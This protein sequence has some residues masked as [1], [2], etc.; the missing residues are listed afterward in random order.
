M[1]LDS[2]NLIEDAQ[3]ASDAHLAAAAELAALEALPAPVEPAPEN[4]PT[5]AE[6]ESA[7]R[8]YSREVADRQ[9][10]LHALSSMVPA[11]A[12]RAATAQT[13]LDAK[14]AQ[15]TPL[16][17]ALVEAV[18]EVPAA[19]LALNTA[20]DGVD[21]ATAALTAAGAAELSQRAGLGWKV[22]GL[23]RNIKIPEVIPDPKNYR[24]YIGPNLAVGGGY[25]AAPVE[26]EA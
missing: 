9:L 5:I 13:A 17:E 1:I 8:D 3:R 19:M 2:T 25:I 11:L 14:V 15:V 23:D 10:R 22:E 20:L 18:L 21:A 12:S 16:Y 7:L 4:F 26:V 6:F 24:V